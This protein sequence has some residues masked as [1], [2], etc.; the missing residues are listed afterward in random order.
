MRHLIKESKRTLLIHLGVLDENSST[1]HG[2][3]NVRAKN[4]LE[5]ASD[6]MDKPVN[7]DYSDTQDLSQ[8]NERAEVFL[9]KYGATFWSTIASH[10]YIRPA[11]K[12]E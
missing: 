12:V 3:W 4:L 6:F 5:R 2:Q 1:H 9:T 8:F 11:H 7:Q 10:T